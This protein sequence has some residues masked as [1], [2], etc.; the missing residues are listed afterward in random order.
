GTPG[1]RGGGG[2]RRTG[3]AV[4]RAPAGDGRAQGGGDRRPGGAQDLPRRADRPL[5]AA[6]ALVADRVGAEDQRRQ[7]RQEGAAQAV[8][9][10]TA[11]RQRGL[12]GARPPAPDREKT[13]AAAPPTGGVA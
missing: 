10:G 13:A 1:G 11:G 5:A 2:R 3:R 4:G 8:R 12:T 6:G 7:V 9:G